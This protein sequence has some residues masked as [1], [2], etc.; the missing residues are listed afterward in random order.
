MSPQALVLSA[1]GRVHSSVHRAHAE[2]CVYYGNIYLVNIFSK[3][4]PIVFVVCPPLEGIFWR[5][6]ALKFVSQ[7]VC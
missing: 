5:K 3:Q 1:T 6:T 7:G 4:N 2:Q